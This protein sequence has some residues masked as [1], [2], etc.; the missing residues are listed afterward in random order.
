MSEGR[1]SDWERFWKPALIGGVGTALVLGARD[2]ARR[3]SRA[4]TEDAEHVEA[5]CDIVGPLLDEWE[6]HEDC[7]TEEDFNRDLR[8]WLR[9]QSDL[10]P[11]EVAP[12]TRDG[13]PDLLIEGALALELKV[14]ASKG[15]LDRLVGQVAGYSREWNTW[16][17]IIDTPR[18]R[19]LRFTR[20][21][22]D[23]RLLGS[24]EYDAICAWA[25]EFEE[26]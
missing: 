8:A 5:V 23:K 3:E 10:D 26:E 15:E 13:C 20:L 24:G 25:I 2:A 14:R 17:V 22:Q 21:L 9:S 7:E 11:I 6:P 19:F 18:S 4:Y 16:A 12:A 1:G